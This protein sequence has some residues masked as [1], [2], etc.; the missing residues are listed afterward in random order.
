M[1][2]AV[3]LRTGTTKSILSTGG[4]ATMEFA[5]VANAAGRAGT[6]LDL[7]VYPRAYT[8]RWYAEVQLQATPTVGQTVD[9]WFVPHDDETTPGRWWGDFSAVTNYSTSGF[10][11]ATENDL[12]N[13]LFCGSIIVDQAAATKF[14]AGGI[15]QL[16]TRYVTPVWWN[17]SGATANA[18]NSNHAMYLT[19]LYDEV[20]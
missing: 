5:S 1:P 4:D 19:P 20:Q 12:R 7:G 2:I 10:S 9:L 17:R 14:T 3:Y 6:R 16:P 18:T 8:W 13:L 11:F 15:V